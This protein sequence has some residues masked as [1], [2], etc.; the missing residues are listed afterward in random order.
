MLGFDVFNFTKRVGDRE[1]YGG[2]KGY[3]AELKGEVPKGTS[4][5]LFGIFENWIEK[6]DF[7]KL[8]EIS[9]AY[10]VTPKLWKM[11]NVRLTLSGRNLVSWDDYSGYDPEVNAAGQDNGCKRI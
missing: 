3:E 6:G 11:R 9:V 2:L 8:R 10:Q 4:T 7:I 5:A 1:L